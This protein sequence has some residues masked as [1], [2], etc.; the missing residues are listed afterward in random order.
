MTEKE[1]K[2]RIEA[3]RLQAEDYGD[4]ERAHGLEDDLHR[5]FIGY[6]KSYFRGTEVGRKATKVL[7]ASR[8]EFP[9]CSA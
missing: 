3:I 1:I 5:D 6:I 2:E 9:R 7:T 8:I 4:P